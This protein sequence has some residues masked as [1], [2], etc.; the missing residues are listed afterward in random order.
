VRE[1]DHERREADKQVD[2][3]LDRR[4]RADEEIYDIPV[5]ARPTAE[6]DETPVE[7][8]DDNEDKR[9]TV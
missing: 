1:A 7:A 5:A 6:R 3:I 2:D 9:D 4:P 8:A